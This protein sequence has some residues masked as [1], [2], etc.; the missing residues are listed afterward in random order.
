LTSNVYFAASLTLSGTVEALTRVP[1]DVS[2]WT[3]DVFRIDRR[4]LAGALAA[5]A[6]G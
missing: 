4:R 6:A 2:A 1:T 5:P 3:P